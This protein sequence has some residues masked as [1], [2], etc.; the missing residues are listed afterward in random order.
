M[1][2][3][4]ATDLTSAHGRE[5]L[6]PSPSTC[7]EDQEGSLS[8]HPFF[9]RT[10]CVT[11]VGSVWSKRETAKETVRQVSSGRRLTHTH[12]R[13][14]LRTEVVQ[15]VHHCVRKSKYGCTN[16]SARVSGDRGEGERVGGGRKRTPE[17][18]QHPDRHRTTQ[19]SLSICRRGMS[20]SKMGRTDLIS[21]FRTRRRSASP[22][23]W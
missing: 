13:P 16:G 17:H 10:L 18:G 7:G 23:G 12:A 15:D 3:R 14:G 4:S 11:D 20:R 2:E 1:G 22:P 9:R 6:C 21:I 19:N 8:L 5:L